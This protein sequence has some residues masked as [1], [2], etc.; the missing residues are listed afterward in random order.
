MGLPQRLVQKLLLLMKQKLS[1]PGGCSKRDAYGT[2]EMLGKIGVLPR[3][4]VQ[5]LAPIA[6]LSQHSRD[7]YLEI[8]WNEVLRHLLRLEDL[9]NFLQ[10]VKRWLENRNYSG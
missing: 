10:H 4:F 3:E 1:P 5:R 6:G 2:I 8:D 7:E 9:Y